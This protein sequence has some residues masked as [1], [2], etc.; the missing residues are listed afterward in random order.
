MIVL[1][2]VNQLIEKFGI[3]IPYVHSY[4]DDLI[5]VPATLG[6]TKFLMYFI[7]RNTYKHLYTPF[8]IFVV[9]CMFSVYFEWYLPE[10]Y[11]YHYRD[12]VDILCYVVGGIFYY[13]FIQKK[14]R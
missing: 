12:Y 3:F 8:Q 6:L 9:I 2:S 4:F 11:P 14:S 7:H 13:H 5:A 1:F 10:K